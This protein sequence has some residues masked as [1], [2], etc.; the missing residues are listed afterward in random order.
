VGGWIVGKWAS[1]RVGKWASGPRSSSLI[2]GYWLI[3]PLCLFGYSLVTGQSVF[4]PRYL[5][6]ALPGAALAA[7]AAAALFLPSK[8]WNPAAA[9]LAIATLV[10]AGQWSQSGR[11]ITTRTG[12]RPRVRSMDWATRP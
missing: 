11:S 4:V 10:F 6:P 7:T 2:L 12:V 9:A 3:P 5:S 1:G 8:A